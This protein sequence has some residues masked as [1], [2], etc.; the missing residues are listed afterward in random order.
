MKGLYASGCVMNFSTNIGY[1]RDFIIKVAPDTDLVYKAFIND[2]GSFLQPRPR[3]QPL[4]KYNVL[5][6]NNLDNAIFVGRY[7]RAELGYGGA[8]EE[9]F[10]EKI[11]TPIWK[12]WICQS[13]FFY[14]PSPIAACYINL[15]FS[16]L[17]EQ[18]YTIHE[19]G[20]VTTYKT[21]PIHATQSSQVVVANKTG[22][23][24]TSASGALQ[25]ATFKG[26]LKE[27]C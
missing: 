5:S 25:R 15:E 20:I 10:T 24:A 12:D 8:G 23:S 21:F 18:P 6:S 22:V 26:S 13:G 17:T 14:L 9:L 1:L 3:M 19:T 16:E 27:G 2:V 7:D 11:W 4:N